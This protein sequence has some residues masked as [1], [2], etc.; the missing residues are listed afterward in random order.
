MSTKWRSY[1]IVIYFFHRSRLLVRSFFSWTKFPLLAFNLPYERFSDFFLV[2][3]N[4]LCPRDCEKRSKTQA[5]KRVAS[6]N[7][8]GKL[9]SEN[10]V[11]FNL[12]VFSLNFWRPSCFLRKNKF[13]TDMSI[14]PTYIFIKGSLRCW[15]YCVVVEWDL[16]AEPSRA[17]K[18]REIPPAREPW[19]FECRP[20]LSP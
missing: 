18:P 15:R 11:V 4:E 12:Q 20:L 7:I 9:K 2:P 19:F 8:D 5:R 13:P 16:T 14:V 3:R 6:I 10:N 1:R 17:A